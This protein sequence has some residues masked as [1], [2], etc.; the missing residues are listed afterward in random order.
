MVLSFL[1]IFFYTLFICWLCRLFGSFPALGVS[2]KE[3]II[4]FYASYDLFL[5]PSW[6]DFLFFT[7]NLSEFL[8]FSIFFIWHSFSFL[9]FVMELWTKWGLIDLSGSGYGLCSPYK[10]LCWRKGPVPLTSHGFL[11]F[12]YPTIPQW[13]G[14]LSLLL[15]GELLVVL[16]FCCG[17]Q[18]SSKASRFKKT[19]KKTPKQTTLC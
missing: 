5:K 17:N 8:F 14:A 9:N 13:M 19:N 2:E 15:S 16:S 6:L 3:F 10:F 18:C 11:R 12:W 1:S 7:F 4:R